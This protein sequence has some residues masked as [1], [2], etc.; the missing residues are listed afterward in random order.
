MRLRIHIKVF[1][2][3]LYIIM[4]KSGIQ[5]CTTN[6]CE[7]CKQIYDKK[8]DGVNSLQTLNPDGHI[9]NHCA[10]L[11]WPDDAVAVAGTIN[12]KEK[13]EKAELRIEQLENSLSRS[14]RVYPTVPVDWDVTSAIL[15]L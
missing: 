4:V 5:H 12:Y 10:K 3:Y 7:V 11:D 6:L 1:I 8:E 13:R 9:K 14:R 2:T 15:K